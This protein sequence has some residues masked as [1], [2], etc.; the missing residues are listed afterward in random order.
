MPA[1]FASSSALRAATIAW[2]SSWVMV[3]AARIEIFGGAPRNR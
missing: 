2:H 1:R 3:D